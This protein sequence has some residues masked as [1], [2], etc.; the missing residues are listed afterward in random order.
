M[1]DYRKSDYIPIQDGYCTIWPNF[2]YFRHSTDLVSYELIIQVIYSLPFIT[3]FRS[4]SEISV[5]KSTNL[6]QMRY[7]LN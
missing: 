3:I 6:T 5:L 2:E 7:K 1:T 4:V